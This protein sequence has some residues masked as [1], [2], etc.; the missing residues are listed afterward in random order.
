MR[1]IAQ[2]DEIVASSGGE[3]TQFN[4]IGH[5]QGGVTSRYVMAARPDLVFSLFLMCDNE[6]KLDSSTV[7]NSKIDET[8]LPL[9]ISNQTAFEKVKAMAD[10]NEMKFFDKAISKSLQG[11]DLNIALPLDRNGDLIVGM[12]L[13]DL[14]ELY[15]S[16]KDEESLDD[17]L[18]RI[19]NALSQQLTS[20]ALEQGYGALKRFIEYKVERV[21]LEQQQRN[22]NLSEL[23][24]LRQKKY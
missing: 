5:S 11:I 1:L 9:L 12:E 16:A 7:D 15:L 18:L 20:P 3:I 13:K 10:S 4:L 21:N 6:N 24:S 8:L 17:I 14:F 23:E 2:L 22:D 19:Q